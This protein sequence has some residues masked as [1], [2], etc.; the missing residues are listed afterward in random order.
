MLSSINSDGIV[1]IKKL[2]YGEGKQ[3]C[4]FNEDIKM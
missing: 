3:L 1:R 4:K 2:E